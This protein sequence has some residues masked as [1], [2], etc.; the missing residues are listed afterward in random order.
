MTECIARVESHV[1]SWLGSPTVLRLLFAEARACGPAVVVGKH[2]LVTSFADVTEVLSDPDFGVKEVYA[3]RMERT[4]GAFFLG[5]DPGP[6]YDREATLARRAVRPGDMATVRAIE[7]QT[8][9]A[10]D[11]EA[12]T[13]GAI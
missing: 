13:R 12:R 11:D 5:M 7:R 8:S 9:E 4:T 10:P 2:A 3:A 1:S 6:Q